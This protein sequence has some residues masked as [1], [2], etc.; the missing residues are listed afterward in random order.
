MCFKCKN[1]CDVEWFGYPGNDKGLVRGFMHDLGLNVHE[2]CVIRLVMIDWL[3]THDS[4]VKYM[5]RMFE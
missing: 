2:L 5:F 3:S 4:V 1:G